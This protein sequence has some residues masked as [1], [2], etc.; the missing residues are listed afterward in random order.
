[1]EVIRDQL[2]HCHFI[3]LYGKM[4]EMLIMKRDYILFCLVIFI[5]FHLNGCSQETYLTERGNREA[6]EGNYDSAI[7]IYDKVL[8]INPNNADIYYNRGLAWAYKRDLENAISDYT[9][10][11][12]IKKDFKDAYHNRGLLFSK[13]GKYNL[14]ILDFTKALQ[15]NP[16]NSQK[17]NIIFNRAYAWSEMNHFEKAIEGYTEALKIHE[18]SK[19]NP[20]DLPEVYYYRGESWYGKGNLDN[21]ISDYTKAIQK[22][23]DYDKAIFR[24]ADRLSENKDYASAIIDYEKAIGL[25]P[26]NTLAHNNYSWLLSTCPNGRFRNGEK[27]LKLALK[28]NELITNEVIYLDT[29]AAAYAEKGN[30]EK[31]IQIEEKAVSLLRNDKRDLNKLKDDFKKRLKSFKAEKPW[32]DNGEKKDWMRSYKPMGS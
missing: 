10:A 16:D 24:R 26:E 19:V 2:I 18:M 5:I 12:E 20:S 14:A 31:A 23:P 32:R 11:L 29:L 6:R 17:L 8:K 4:E 7:N 3:S 27:A 28:A 21:A 25:N 22:K 15:L 30:F 13:M 9:K 1:M